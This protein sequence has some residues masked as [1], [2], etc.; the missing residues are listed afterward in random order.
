MSYFKHLVGHWYWHF[1]GRLSAWWNLELLTHFNVTE[2][3][4][5]CVCECFLFN[6]SF[7]YI[8]HFGA[9]Q[10]TPY[11]V[12]QENVKVWLNQRTSPAWRRSWLPGNAKT[13]LTN[14]TLRLAHWYDETQRLHDLYDLPMINAKPL[15]KYIKLMSLLS[16]IHLHVLV[17]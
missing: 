12:S 2:R 14:Q 8:L 3:Y 9:I 11:Y 15:G 6:E 16:C 7:I 10:D 1:V 17:I 13:S 4:V 5:S